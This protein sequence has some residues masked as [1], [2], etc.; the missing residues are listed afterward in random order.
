MRVNPKERANG[1]EGVDTPSEAAVLILRNCNGA[2]LKSGIGTRG[3]FENSHRSK[4][5]REGRHVNG[6]VLSVRTRRVTVSL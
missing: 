3:K 5:R 1:P 4:N 2:N 6:S